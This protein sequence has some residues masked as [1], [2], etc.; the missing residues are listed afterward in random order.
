MLGNL[1]G[2]RRAGG[3]GP[4]ESTALLQLEKRR[5]TH[6]DGGA[7]AAPGRAGAGGSPLPSK[8]S[9]VPVGSPA[10]RKCTPGGGDAVELSPAQALLLSWRRARMLWR[11]HPVVVVVMHV[12]VAAQV[13]ELQKETRTKDGKRRITPVAIAPLPPLPTRAP[14]TT[15]R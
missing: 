4:L 13:V 7:P 8:A 2:S 9:R 11:R 12:V 1:Y 6:A 14:L 10:A 15:P 3:S 5:A